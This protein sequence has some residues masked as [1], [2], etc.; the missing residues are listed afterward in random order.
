MKCVVS[1]TVWL[2]GPVGQDD[3]QGHLIV[4]DVE[5]TIEATTKALAVVDDAMAMLLAER[6]VCGEDW[7]LSSVVM[8]A[9]PFDGGE[10]RSGENFNLEAN[11][12]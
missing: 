4:E 10:G 3:G 2:S 7:R 9:A 5:S 11:N 12:A 6:K 1:W 8:S